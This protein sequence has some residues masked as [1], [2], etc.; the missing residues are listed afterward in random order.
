MK[1]RTLLGRT[2][3][4]GAAFALA[5][6]LR[7]DRDETPLTVSDTSFGE[8]EDGYLVLNVTISNPTERSASGTAYVNSQLNGNSS[9]RVRQVDLDAHSTIVFQI[10]YDVKYANIT[11]YQPS[12]DIDQ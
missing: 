7:R 4:A 12:V 2:A 11:N 1:R 5:G 6:C 8:G 9:T 3:A 10:E